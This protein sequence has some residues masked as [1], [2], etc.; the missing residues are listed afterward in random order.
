MRRTVHK[1]E[2]DWCGEYQYGSTNKTLR[3]FARY[4]R[5]SL[6]WLSI[7]KEHDFCS[8]LCMEHWLEENKSK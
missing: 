2:C 7:G 3:E 4:L 1:I 8:E 5:G 6:S